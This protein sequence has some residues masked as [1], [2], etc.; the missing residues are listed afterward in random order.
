MIAFFESIAIDLIAFVW[1]LNASIRTKSKWLSFFGTS[2]KNLKT[3]SLNPAAIVPPSEST[4]N[5]K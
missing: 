5:E 1:G 2:F 4:F 3:P